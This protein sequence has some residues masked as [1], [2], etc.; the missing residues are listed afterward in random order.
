MKR[1]GTLVPGDRIEVAIEKAVYRGLGLARHEGQVVFVPRGLPGERLVVRVASIER[2]YAKAVAEERRDAAA[3]SRTA[4]CAAFPECGGCAYQSL[5]Y[6]AQLD[7][8]RGMLRESL[9]RGGIA[10]NGEI[11][12]TS[13]PEEGWR[14]RALFHVSV[15][16]GEVALGFF[17][18]G[19]RRVVDLPEGCPQ[20]SRELREVL[21]GAREVLSKRPL[22]ARRV[23]NL[24]V[25]ESPDGAERVLILEGDLSAAEAAALGGALSSPRLSGIGASL[26]PDASR[27]LVT[28]GGS[29]HVRARVLGV[30]LQ[31]HAAAFFQGNRFLVEPLA[32]EVGR[33]L[34]KGGALLD[35]YGGGGLFGLTSG[36]DAD[37]V[38]I[39][40][41][42]DLSAADAE[43][44]ARVLGLGHARVFKGDVAKVL[45][46]VRRSEAERIVV[47]PPRAGL[48]RPVAEAIGA[49]RPEA[50]VYVSCD[51]ATLARDL[52]V[53]GS[54][55]LVADS[56][57]MLDMFPDSFHIESVVRLVQG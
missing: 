30:S 41:G 20:V 45:A 55:G 7:L 6:E 23:A 43:E 44:N 50:V 5:D 53:L 35:L 34:P 11:P 24:R 12:A 28:L 10:W 33:L 15:D 25:A 21:H 32:A 4:P 40:E 13:S 36:R 56:V 8:K 49:R 26:G 31:S 22:P 37:S 16:R 2:G 29:L 9:G 39:V 54:F 1:K 51:P 47:D 42:N 38:S 48:S 14:I 17:E 18:E 52:R 3:G 57:R 27:R 19:S 46:G